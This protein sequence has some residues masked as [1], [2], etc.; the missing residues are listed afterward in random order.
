MV[1]EAPVLTPFSF[2]PIFFILPSRKP[3]TSQGDR[4][5][6]HGRGGRAPTRDGKRA[7]DRRSGT[8]R[9]R[10]TKKDGGGRGNWGS[11]KAAAKANEGKVVDEAKPVTDEEVAAT[12]EVREEQPAPEPEP[13]DNTMTLAE[14]NAAKT[15]KEAVVDRE[16]DNEFAGKVAAI[17]VEEDFLV[18][19][20]GKSKKVPKKNVKKAAPVALGFR[21]VS[22]CS[23]WWMSQQVL[24]MARLYLTLCFLS[25]YYSFY[26]ETYRPNPAAVM[27]EKAAV[28]EDVAKA[29]VDVEKAVVDAVRAVADEEDAVAEEKAV[30]V[31][32]AVDAVKAA[33][34]A[35]VDEEMLPLTSWTPLPFPLCRWIVMMVMTLAW[36]CWLT[37]CA[38]E[39]DTGI[40]SDQWPVRAR[41]VGYSG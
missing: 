3:A 37:E 21:V 40:C 24:K 11:D 16:V 29:A 15:A 39:E 18:L 17:K 22:S 27:T 9:G 30:G 41:K 35:D 5:T 26:Y 7:Y 1:V 19:G 31:V 4:N 2:L 12:E 32:R 25:R 36:E 8:G 33:E 38:V 14:Y 13:Q 23:W 28:E 34:E 6:K 20:A 10:E